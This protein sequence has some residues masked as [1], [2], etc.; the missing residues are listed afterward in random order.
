MRVPDRDPDAPGKEG[1]DMEMRRNRVPRKSLDVSA[2]AP[3][4]PPT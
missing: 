2:A 4:A 3:D 1:T